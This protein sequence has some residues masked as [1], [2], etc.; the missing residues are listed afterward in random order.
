MDA[1]PNK[2]QTTITTKLTKMLLITPKKSGADV[3]MESDLEE[4]CKLLNFSC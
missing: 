2:Y 4:I 1:D 3:K